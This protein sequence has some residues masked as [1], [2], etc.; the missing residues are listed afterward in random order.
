MFS[1][2]FSN[3]VDVIFGPSFFACAGRNAAARARRS[4]TDDRMNKLKVIAPTWEKSV[5]EFS[6]AIDA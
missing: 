4:K 3:L 2:A 6:S 1:R 5:G